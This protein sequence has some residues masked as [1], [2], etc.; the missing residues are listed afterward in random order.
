MGS[1]APVRPVV[2]CVL[3]GFGEREA[4]EGNAIRLAGTPELDRLRKRYPSCSLVASGGAVGLPEGLSADGRLGHLLLGAGR[5]VPSARQHIDQVIAQRKLGKNAI[6]GQTLRIATD[7]RARLHVVCLLSDGGMHASLGHLF[8]LLELADF[9]EVKV[10]LHAILDGRDMPPRSAIGVIDRVERWLEGKGSIGTVSGRHYAMDT[11]DNWDRLYRVFHAIV[12]DK[13]LG[14]EAPQAA[15]AF[16]A[17]HQAYGQG[18]GD[19][20]VPP[21]RVGDY[22][23]LCGDFLCDFASNQ[24]VWEWTGEE[25]GLALHHRADGIAALCAML[26]R[27]A[28]PP[29]V[30]AD[31]LTDRGKPVLAFAEHCFATL[32]AT[33]PGTSL[34]VAFPTEPLA[35][36]CADAVARA[37]LTQLRCAETLKRAHVTEFFGGGALAPLPGERR[38]LVPSPLDVERY[39]ERPALRTAEVAAAVTQAVRDGEADFVL[40]N[41]GAADVVAHTGNLEATMAAVRAVDRALGEIAR[42]VEARGGALLVASDHGNAELVPAPGNAAHPAP[43]PS[44]VPFVLAHEPLRGTQLATA[45]NLCDVAPTLLELLGIEAPPAMTGRSLLP[46]SS[47]IP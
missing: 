12:R 17:L 27:S 5:A 29:D 37:G 44:A 32:V 4:H 6:I 33:E 19:E 9:H 47:R 15:T 22:Q 41:L 34:P 2:L 14:P 7:R 46:S 30:V 20:L 26:T 25:V 21:T 28:L 36:S 10:V 11:D 13:T 8:E 45:G 38:I 24:P 35:D 40:V 1:S 31:L 3:D 39:D 42:A 18:L 23:G 16:D 43:A